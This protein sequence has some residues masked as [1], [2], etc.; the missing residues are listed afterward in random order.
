MKPEHYQMSE[1]Q[2][3]LVGKQDRNNQSIDE[4]EEQYRKSLLATVPEEE[5]IRV[6]DMALHGTRRYVVCITALKGFDK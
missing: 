4:I 1:V 6:L 3:H 5:T 2:T